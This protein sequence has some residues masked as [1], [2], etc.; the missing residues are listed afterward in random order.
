[1]RVYFITI[2]LLLSALF[3]V[4]Q[5]TDL[6]IKKS[7]DKVK[8]DGKYFYIHIVRKGETLY[9]ISK[10]YNVS[11]I[12]IA[13][14]NPDIYLG[15]Q[16]DQALKIPIKDSQEDLPRGNEDDNYIYHVVRKG[17]TLFG[18]SRKYQLPMEAIIKVN[19]EVE[20]G[21]KLSQV[22]LIPKERVET[23]GTASPQESERFIY[24]EV[25]P[26]EGFYAISRQYNVS[27]KIIRQYNADLV[28]D[29][30]KL[31]TILKIPRNPEDTLQVVSFKQP[32]QEIAASGHAY[33]PTI[34]VAVCDTFK[35]DSR[36]HIYNVAL[37][38][39]LFIYEFENPPIDSLELQQMQ[40]RGITEIKPKIPSKS[41]NFIDFY[42]G[43]LLAVDSLKQ[44]GLS[45]NLSVF[46]TGKDVEVVKGLLRNNALKEADLII[47]PVYPECIKPVADFAREHRIPVVSPLSPNNYLLNENPYLFQANPSFITQ[48]EEFS[49]MIDLCSDRNLVLIHE[50]DSTANSMVDAFK[51]FIRQR[52]G[53]CSNPDFI[54]FK[55]VTYKPGSPVTEITEMISHSLVQDKEN[56]IMVPSNNEAFVADLLGN[57]HTLSTYYAYPISVYGLPRW[58]RFR[59]VQVDYYYKLQLHLFSPFFLDYASS[60]LKSFI[61]KYRDVYRSEPTQFS[62]Q[63]Y[64]VF[65]YFLSAMKR[66]GPDFKF[67]ISHHKVSLLQSE[68]DFK[69]INSI[70]GFENRAVYMIKYNKNFE[71]QKVN[72]T[73]GSISNHLQY[74]DES[75]IQP[76]AIKNRP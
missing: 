62:F 71:I 76:Q 14:E 10:A 40:A 75:S 53:K 46:D 43:A 22:V 54:H 16:I 19:P 20:T 39:P 68:F 8:I 13:V 74:H 59:N 12:E 41:T 34:P 28:S 35:Y 21:L 32:S 11:Q 7:T 42:Q 66:F 38:L 1:M 5:E 67:C 37:L 9:S 3:V 63:G 65:Y 23:L 48:L 15:I 24:H 56:L 36:K 69:Q 31:G 26:R 51:G 60:D 17:E 50:A 45:V 57:L 64:D 52:I 72:V 49:Q 70:S 18:L 2:V 27:E 61:N 44:L 47:G 55:E 73:S 25:K 29:G 6:K 4:G 33:Q 30:L 58:Q